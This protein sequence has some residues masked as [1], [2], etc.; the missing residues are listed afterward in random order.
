[1]SNSIRQHLKERL[2]RA[3]ISRDDRRAVENGL[4]RLRAGFQL[5]RAR[6]GASD[7]I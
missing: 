2:D 7:Q 4:H 1:M 3:R 6:T 5:E